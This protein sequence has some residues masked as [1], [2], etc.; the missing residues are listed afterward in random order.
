M[1]GF[2][3]SKFR[4]NKSVANEAARERVDRKREE[5]ERERERERENI[6]FQ[7]FTGENLSPKIQN[8]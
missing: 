7:K 5:R 2:D 4:V 3:R 8:R 6:N 1:N